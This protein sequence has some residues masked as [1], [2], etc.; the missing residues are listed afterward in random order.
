MTSQEQKKAGFITLKEA[1]ERFGYAPDYIGQ[2][3]RKGKLEGRQVYANM[4]WMTTPEALEEYIAKEKGAGK[5]EKE[6]FTL[7]RLMDTV[8]GKKLNKVLVW[9]LYGALG[10]LAAF[11]LVLFYVLSI[12]LEHHLNE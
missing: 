11:L 9:M 10:F 1:S 5:A 6:K 12:L 4:A 7:D 3:I 2:L 8:F